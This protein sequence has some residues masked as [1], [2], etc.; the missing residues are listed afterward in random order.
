VTVAVPTKSTVLPLPF[1]TLMVMP[2]HGWAFLMS[3][4]YSARAAGKV[5]LVILMTSIWRPSV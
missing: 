2:A 1:V 4:R 5:A 3:S